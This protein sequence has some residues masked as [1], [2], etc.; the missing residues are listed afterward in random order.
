MA[1]SNRPK[2]RKPPPA[3][4]QIG[5]AS[6]HAGCL[7]SLLDET[8][9]GSVAATDDIDALFTPPHKQ[10]LIIW[11]VLFASPFR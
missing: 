4:Q 9:R 11:F 1:N 3:M 5:T 8:F 6:A 10:L 7:V 2:K